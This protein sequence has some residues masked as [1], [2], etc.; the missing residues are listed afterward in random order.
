MAT[1]A[2]IAAA[3]ANAQHS[4]GPR[5]PDGKA[6]SS[7]NAT[8]LGL[9]AQSPILPGE[10]PKELAA[11]TR[12]YLDEYKPKTPTERALL[13]DLVLADWFKRRYRRIETEIINAR[14]AALPEEERNQNALGL[15]FIQDAEGPK[16]LDKIFR[17]EQAASRQFHRAL[18]ELRKAIVERMSLMMQAAVAERALPPAANNAMEKRTG[19]EPAPAPKNYNG[20]TPVRT[21]KDNWDNPAL[22]L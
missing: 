3:V 15:I 19:S 1:N 10:D 11:L 17:R 7:M 13:D 12:D 5:S 21:P 22:R 16:L 2:Q 8:K 9:F 18:T 20:P 14:F 6:A 4:T